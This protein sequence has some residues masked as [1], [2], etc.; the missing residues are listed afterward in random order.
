MTLYSLLLKILK[1]GD[2]TASFDKEFYAVIKRCEK[3][4]LWTFRLD[5]EQ[6]S[7]YTCPRVERLGGN[8]NKM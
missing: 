8:V 7:L 4:W 1:D 2:V 5:L 6:C 3:K